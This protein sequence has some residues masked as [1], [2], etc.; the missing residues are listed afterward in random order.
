MPDRNGTTLDVGDGVI[1]ALGAEEDGVGATVLADNGDGTYQIE[2]DHQ[3]GRPSSGIP[4]L[5]ARRLRAEAQ[6]VGIDTE[7]PLTAPAEHLTLYARPDDAWDDE[8]DE[9]IVSSEDPPR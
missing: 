3:Q 8:G 9:D 1:Y 6:A 2:L 7:S 5:T 4:N